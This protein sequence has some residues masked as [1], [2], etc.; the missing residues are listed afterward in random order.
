MDAIYLHITE[1]MFA[2]PIPTI[3]Q[4]NLGAGNNSNN[5]QFKGGFPIEITEN[6]N[7]LT[8]G[9]GSKNIRFQNKVIPFGLAMK[10]VKPQFGYQCKNGDVLNNDMF[11]KLFN[12]VAKIE[13]TNG[14]KNTVLNKTKKIQK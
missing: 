4:H 9:G 8:D 2:E 14:Y 12:T 1:N 3:G 13:R 10:K 6:S 11:E 7:G 5:H